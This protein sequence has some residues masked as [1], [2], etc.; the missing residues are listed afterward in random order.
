[1]EQLWFL[2]YAF[3]LVSLIFGIFFIIKKKICGVFQVLLSILVPVW[4]FIF[5]MHR[6][7]VNSNEKEFE[8]FCSQ[9]LNGSLEAILILIL[10]IILVIIFIY[11]I[12]RLKLNKHYK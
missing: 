1:M 8:F 12:S 5:V 11:N 4:F 3:F 10:F 6:D 9:L 2:C 7:W